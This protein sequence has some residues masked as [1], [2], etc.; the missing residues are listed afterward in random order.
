MCARM[1]LPTAVGFELWA[2]QRLENAP[3]ETGLD[4]DGGEFFDIFSDRSRRICYPDGSVVRS[5]SVVFRIPIDSRARMRLSA[6]SRELQ[7]VRRS[8]RASLNFASPHRIIRERY[9]SGASGPF[10]E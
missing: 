2:S 7:V 5:I 1:A 9:L 6:E 3:E 8:E 10:F 4:A